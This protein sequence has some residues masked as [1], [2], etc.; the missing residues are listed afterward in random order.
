ME[1]E[2]FY[3]TPGDLSVAIRKQMVNIYNFPLRHYH[4][5]SIGINMDVVSPAFW[6]LL[7][8]TQVQ[9]MEV[10]KNLCEDKNCFIIRSEKYIEHIFSELYSVPE[11]IKA[12]Y[13]KVKILELLLVLSGND[14][15]N[16]Q[17]RVGTLAKSQVQFAN[18]VA[19]YLGEQ[20]N[21]HITIE[22]LAKN[23]NVSTT[24]L[25]SIFRD[26]YGVPI[27]TYMRIQ[28]MQ[29][30]AQLLIHT[31]RAITDI[32]YEFGYSNVSK[33]SAAFQKIMGETPSAYRKE[34]TKH[35]LT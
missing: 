33:F 29:L 34:H 24:Y 28:K 14:M 10:A 11:N 12:G 15:Y 1:E 6:R 21:Q 9:P 8:E 17:M 19:G 31:E 26:V 32:S 27:F 22:E 18:K 3:L 7:E 13:F 4:G 5:I 35:R 16:K 30:A 25:K 2:Y 20:M 23:F